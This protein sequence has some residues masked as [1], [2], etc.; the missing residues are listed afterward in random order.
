MRWSKWSFW[1]LHASLCCL[2]Y[3]AILI[4]PLT[5]WR[6]LLPAKRTFYR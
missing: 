1:L 4:L 3:A 6:D 5:Q 2:V